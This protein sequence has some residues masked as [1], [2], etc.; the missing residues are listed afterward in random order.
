M[1][2]DYQTKTFELKLTP[3]CLKVRVPVWNYTERWV[4]PPTQELGKWALNHAIPT[5]PPMGLKVRVLFTL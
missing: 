2:R 3:S 4:S 1:G 5:H